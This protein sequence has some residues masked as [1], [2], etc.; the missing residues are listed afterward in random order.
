MSDADER[1]GTMAEAIETALTAE[2]RREER[3]LWRTQVTY[4][5]EEPWQQHARQEHRSHE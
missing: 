3:A 4:G 2:E 5:W 1:T